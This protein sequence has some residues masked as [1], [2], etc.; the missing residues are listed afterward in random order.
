MSLS[1]M[2]LNRSCKG[3]SLKD[4][5]IEVKSG[6]Y[7]VLLGPTGAG[8][9]MLLETIMGIRRPDSGKIVLNG[10]EITDLPTERRG[11]GYVPQ[12]SLLFPHM[13]VRQNVEFGL[14]I[15][16]TPAATLKV[17]ADRVLTE[18]GILN[19]ADRMPVSLSGGETQKVALARVMVIEPRL[20]L[21]DEPL[22]AIDPETRQAL[23]DYLKGKQSETG[24]SFLHVTHDQV[25]AFSMAN[26]IAL[27]KGGMIMQ[28]GSP[29]EIF[30]KPKNEFVA[31]FLGY[32]NIFRGQAA[33]RADGLLDIDIGGGA[34]VVSAGAAEQRASIG[35]GKVQCVLG[36]RTDEI[37]ISDSPDSNTINV[38]QGVIEDYAD[39]GSIVKVGIRAEK[40][41]VFH[42]TLTANAFISGSLDRGKKVW[43]SFSPNSIKVLS[44]TSGSTS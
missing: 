38:F 23:R 7:F 28:T 39:L 2:G 41:P 40:G 44:A 1:I 27:I 26:Q 43:I 22:S 14:K 34:I 5:Q 11:I 9:T 18:L 31:R 10:V 6:E 29:K 12:Q 20:V 3:L 16:G 33:R 35:N 36:L 32:E 24:T 21:L 25:E 19:L 17:R 13:T 42:V 8:K 30:S 15:R 37:A 4:I